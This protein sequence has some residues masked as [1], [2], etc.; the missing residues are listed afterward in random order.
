MGFFNDECDLVDDDQYD[1]FTLAIDVERRSAGW[2]E[3]SGDKVSVARSR[4]SERKDAAHS[5]SHG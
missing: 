4:L 1:L 5:S 3:S 2:Q